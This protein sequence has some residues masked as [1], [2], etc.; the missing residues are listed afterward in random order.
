MSSQK[1]SKKLEKV[2]HLDM[3]QVHM[4]VMEVDESKCKKCE[5]CFAIEN[6]PLRAWEREGQEIP[7]MKKIHECFSCSNCMVACPN[8]AVQMIE[9]Y[10]VDEGYFKT[11]PC[12]LPYKLPFDLRMRK[13]IQLNIQK[14]KKPS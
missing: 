11:E 10:H 14:S 4:G 12:P 6:C 2:L 7:V 8:N 9:P 1:K 3:E 5:I 13:G